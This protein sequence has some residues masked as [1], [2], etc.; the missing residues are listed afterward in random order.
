MLNSAKL[1]SFSVVQKKK[2][3]VSE[4]AKILGITWKDKVKEEIRKRTG[5]KKLEDMITERR[6]RW[7]RHYVITDVGDK[8]SSARFKGYRRRAGRP[9]NKCV[10]PVPDLLFWHNTIKSNYRT[11]NEHGKKQTTANGVDLW[12][13]VKCEPR[14]KVQGI[15]LYDKALCL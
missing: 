6:R 4:N 10:V 5:L 14:S 9:I 3:L 7:L 11:W 8:N 13:S 12:P 2:K 15:C 1:W